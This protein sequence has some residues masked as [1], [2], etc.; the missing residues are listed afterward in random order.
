MQAM[1]RRPEAAPSGAAKEERR[2]RR[3]QREGDR[4]RPRAE[5]WPHLDWRVPEAVLP[6]DCRVGRRSIRGS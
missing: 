1:N 4:E 5:R 3:R 6:E 2:K